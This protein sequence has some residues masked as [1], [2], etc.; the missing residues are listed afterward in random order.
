[1]E[2]K[3][4][5]S[6]D[7]YATAIIK[8]H[9]GGYVVSG[10]TKS[11][12]GDITRENGG[13]DAWLIKIDDNGNRV[14]SKNYGGSSDD[15][16][17]TIIRTNDNSYMIAGYSN[18]RD[19][20]VVGNKGGYDEWVVKI[21]LAGNKQWAKTFGGAT[22][23]FGNGLVT[24]ADGGY[25]LAGYTNSTNGDV[26]RPGGDFGG[27][28]VKFDG[29]GNKTAVSTYGDSFDNFTS[30]LINTLDSG[31]LLSGY[32]SLSNTTSDAWLVKVLDLR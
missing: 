24:T 3:L 23:D 25:M 6:L 18:S 12:D 19:G 2:P 20:D 32:S 26:T 14:W 31:Y 22:D 1:V 9:D 17:K 11:A 29:N 8:A 28:L 16:A 27:F 4:R 10:Y 15:Y 13:V 7:D 21:D 5:G 30:A